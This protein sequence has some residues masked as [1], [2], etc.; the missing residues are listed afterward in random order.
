[1]E[2][3]L[4]KYFKNIDGAILNQTILVKEEG[5]TNISYTHEG[6]KYSLVSL[7]GFK[8]LYGDIDIESLKGTDI[9]EMTIRNGWVQISEED[10]KNAVKKFQDDAIKKIKSDN[11]GGK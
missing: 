4:T 1:M 7:G 8:E 10:Y 9:S 3:T 2:I 11:R 5:F 6:K